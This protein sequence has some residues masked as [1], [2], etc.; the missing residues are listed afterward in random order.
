[1]ITINVRPENTPSL[2]NGCIRIIEI[3]LTRIIHRACPD[4]SG[5]FI[6]QIRDILAESH[7]S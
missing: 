7:T 3:D 2:F 4:P 1:M 5:K 6:P